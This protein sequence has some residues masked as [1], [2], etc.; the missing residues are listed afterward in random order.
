MDRIASAVLGA[1]LWMLGTE[2][3]NCQWY[4]VPAGGRVTFTLTELW[5]IAKGIPPNSYIEG[6]ATIMLQYLDGSTEQIAFQDSGGIVSGLVTPQSG[7]GISFGTGSGQLFGTSVWTQAASLTAGGVF[8]IVSATPAQSYAQDVEFQGGTGAFV[9]GFVSKFSADAPSVT[10]PSG[11]AT[12][13]N[14]PPPPSAPVGAPSNIRAVIVS[15][16]S[17]PAKSPRT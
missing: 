8:Q 17:D 2:A 5:A 6:D 13:S 12:T 3:G 15:G 14:L 1:L 10:Q 16:L 4:K 11:L 7:S 9:K